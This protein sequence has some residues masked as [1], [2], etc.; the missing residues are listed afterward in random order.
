[1]EMVRD[2]PVKN[3]FEISYLMFGIYLGIGICF[4]EFK[5]S[6][7]AVTSKNSVTGS[8]G[9]S[10]NNPENPLIL[11]ILVQTYLHTV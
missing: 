7:P 1:M 9:N 10:K 11:K 3:L 8:P 2:N 5:T 6:L 4:L